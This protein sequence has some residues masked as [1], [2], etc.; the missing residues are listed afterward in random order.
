MSPSQTMASSRKTSQGSCCWRRWRAGDRQREVGDRRTPARR[1]RPGDS[2]D[3]RARGEHQTA[4]ADDAEDAERQSVEAV[5]L[6]PAAQAERKARR[7]EG[8]EYRQR[9][10][11]CA[12]RRDTRE[13]CELDGGAGE[14]PLPRAGRRPS[15]AGGRAPTSASGTP[16]AAVRRRFIGRRERLRLRPSAGR[17]GTSSIA[18]LDA[19]VAALAAL[20]VED[21]LEQVAAAEVGPEGRGH[22]DLGVGDLPEQEVRDPQLARGADQQVGVGLARR[23]EVARRAS[24][25]RCRPACRPPSRRRCGGRRRRSRSGPS[26]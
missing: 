1:R 11:G 2:I 8:H 25:R 24:P 16:T 20:E 14:R 4:G 12:R 9:P 23:V 19:A 15:P 26:S 18:R 10:P 22:P 6:D 13:A 7:G 5:D 17:A 3:R 21:R